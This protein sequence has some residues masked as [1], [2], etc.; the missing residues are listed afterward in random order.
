MAKYAGPPGDVNS[1]SIR[2]RFVS[3]LT[4]PLEPDV[5]RRFMNHAPNSR[6]LE[7]YYYL[8]LS[9]TIDMTRLGIGKGTDS[10]CTR[11]PALS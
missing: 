5:T 4:S 7:E 6:M 8:N 2:R 10:T 3:E 1:Y 9:D 11:I